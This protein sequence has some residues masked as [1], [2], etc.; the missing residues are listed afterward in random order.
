MDKE[1]S[2]NLL[3]K[4]AQICITKHYG[5][6]DKMGC[7]YFQH[8]MRVALR[9]DTD[10]QRM[11][12]LLH[13]VMEDAGVT[14]DQ[15]L[16]EGFPQEVIDGVL[17]VSRQQGENYEDFV[18]RAKQ[19]PLGRAVKLHDL[20][21]NLDILR[22]DAFSPDM[23]QRYA[24]YLAAY[25]FLQSD[26]PCDTAMPSRH[27]TKNLSEYYSTCRAEENKLI[28]S[29]SKAIS[30]TNRN[31]YRLYV[32]DKDKI[33]IDETS[34]FNTLVALGRLISFDKMFNSSI[35]VQR[36]RYRYQL[37]CKSS[38]SNVYTR[39]T[40]GWLVLSNVPVISTA[41]ALNAF[42]DEINAHYI[43]SIVIR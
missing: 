35:R 33:V 22:L 8:P 24:K 26:E 15:L 11:V 41:L 39:D 12:A 27:K 38:K 1:Q 28:E 20:E 17:A 30:G 36:E 42:F 32:R 2:A 14:T 23:A 16:A 40:S 29:R 21:D 7:A 31:V 4:A 37:V 5:Q 13:D 9:C 25:R 19:N 3:D 43:A 34:I 6:R 10:E 18:A